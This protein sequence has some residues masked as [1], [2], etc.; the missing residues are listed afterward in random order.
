MSC[1]EKYCVFETQRSSKTQL[2]NDVG[3]TCRKFFSCVAGMSRGHPVD[4]LRDLKSGV[5]MTHDARRASL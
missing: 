2:H 5:M 3:S 1:L 4:V